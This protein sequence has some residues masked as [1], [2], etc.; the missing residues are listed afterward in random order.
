LN[1]QPVPNVHSGVSVE[2]FILEKSVSFEDKTNCFINTKKPSK[3]YTCFILRRLG[4]FLIHL[5][6]K[7]K[8]TVCSVSNSKPIGIANEALVLLGWGFSNW[9]TI[10]GQPPTEQL[11][12]GQLPTRTIANRTIDN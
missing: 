10:Q 2:R 1:R 4:L 6:S 11:P 8:A 9:D 5:Q 7:N 12:T 3:N